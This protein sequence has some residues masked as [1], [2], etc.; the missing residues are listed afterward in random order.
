MARG[1]PGGFDVNALMKQAQKMQDEMLQAQ[2]SLKDEVVEASAG[3]GMVKVKMGGDLTL[4]EIV[5]DPEA[6]DPEDAEMLAEMVQAAVNE[7]LRAAQQLA[8]SKMGGITGGLGGLP[9]M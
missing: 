4:R 3:G 8:E 1:G 7:G 2:E 6:I 9:G 5:I